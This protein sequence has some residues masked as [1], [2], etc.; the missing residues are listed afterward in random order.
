M[1]M[2]HL[3][4][5]FLRSTCPFGRPFVCRHGGATIWTPCV[6]RSLSTS[7]ARKT[8]NTFSFR[9][10]ART[11]E[12]L[13]G[14]LAHFQLC[15]QWIVTASDWRN[16]KR[17]EN[18]IQT[19]MRDNSNN[20]SQRL[21]VRSSARNEDTEGSS[22]AGAYL[23]LSDVAPTE[24]GAAIDRVLAS[25]QRHK[26]DQDG[27]CDQEVLVQPM[28][29]DVV[30]SGVVLTRELDSGSPYYVIN[31]DAETTRTDGVTGGRGES[32]SLLVRRAAAASVSAK[33]TSSSALPPWVPLLLDSTIE[34]EQVTECQELD[35]EFCVDTEHTIFLLQVRPLAAKA[36]WTPVP[37]V[38]IDRA[39]EDV[40]DQLGHYM[41]TT[42]KVGL[43]GHTTIFTEMT[44]WN[45]AE[46]I[47]T[48][49]RPL[50]LSLYRTLITDSVW[51]QARE[52]MGY[53]KVDGPLLQSFH[54]RPFIDVR[55]SLNS[56]LPAGL[57]TV[58]GED[59]VA[60]K[61]IN[62]Q[63]DKLA[64][65]PE[66]H[67]KV[68]F[69]VAL[70][71]WDFST[72]KSRQY[73]VD[74]GLNTREAGDMESLLQDMTRNIIQGG[75][76]HLQDLLSATDRLLDDHTTLTGLPPLARV[77]RLLDMCRKH[78]TLPFS[79][80]ARHAFISRQLLHSMVSE[81]ILH[82]TDVECFMQSVRTVAIDLAQD[83]QRVSS[84]SLERD[85]FL[86]TYGHLRPNTYEITSWSYNERPDL[87]LGHFGNTAS[88]L[89]EFHL[90]REI[91]GRVERALEQVGFKVSA[92]DL[93]WCFATAIEG[94]EKA[95][96]AFTKTV[97]DILSTIMKWGGNDFKRE[98]LSFL[99]VEDILL[100]S[101][102]QEN[103]DKIRAAKDI[104][105]LTRSIRLPHVIVEPGDVDIIRL[106]LGQ[107]NFITD[108]ST[109]AATV[110]LTPDKAAKVDGRIVMIENADPG[111]D[112]IFSHP[113]GGLITMYGGANSHMAIRCA[114]FG[115]PAA[116][117]CGER[118]FN[119]LKEAS[120]VELN[121]AS[122]QL[123][124]QG[125]TNKHE[126]ST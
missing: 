31:Y 87:F 47:G 92:D 62:Y 67:D 34:L 125:W 100:D 18:M 117:G 50:A 52:C 82:K 126:H 124:S 112:W 74:A 111:F 58:D 119:K 23:S 103:R 86:K 43:A 37:D 63:L 109:T 96:F 107:P 45:P 9:S 83:L 89:Q 46:M 53:R 2:I 60:N 32:E 65:R 78:G 71:C 36:K 26:D 8:P 69:E 17:R 48:T 70:T 115:L 25:Y 116:I 41:K 123:N 22:L 94:R 44:D 88:T 16:D 4:R 3:R 1:M 55:K 122:K 27:D 56:F 33:S 101:S 90:S 42:P 98:D 114:E 30:A 40:R 5:P 57:G 91:V 102:I 85:A 110:F 12:A 6:G 59:V 93:F 15:P 13:Q 66:L 106:P 21:M 118:L 84:G 19:V 68:E 81:G 76:L 29:D 61:L 108:K 10:K 24:L 51:A 105:R 35:L 95:K 39:V 7:T 49:P 20:K 99:S 113:I 11:L 73:F 97:S 121:A 75:A 38:E 14:R 72:S 28:V 64:E 80:L 104:Y 54:G 120:V 77:S 79:Q